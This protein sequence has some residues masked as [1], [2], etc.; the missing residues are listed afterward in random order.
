M[1]DP[2]PITRARQAL[3]AARVTAAWHA[4]VAAGDTDP[5]RPRRLCAA[6]RAQLAVLAVT[7]DVAL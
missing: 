1:S 6:I 4:A 3:A 5:G 2:T 7:E